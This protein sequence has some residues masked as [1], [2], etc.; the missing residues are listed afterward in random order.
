MDIMSPRQDEQK[1]ASLM[2]VIDYMLDR[3]EETVV[4]RLDSP[5][6]AAEH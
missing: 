2:T 3:Y 6:L 5:L 1:I 4:Y